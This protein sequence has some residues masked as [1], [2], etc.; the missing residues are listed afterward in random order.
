[1]AT[2]DAL[3][4]IQN[5]GRAR[6][7]GFHGEGRRRTGAFCRQSSG[8]FGPVLG[9][10]YSASILLVQRLMDGA[11]P[12]CPQLYFGVV[13]VRD[14]ADL[15]IR[16]MTQPAAKG[17]R[18]LAVAGDFMTMLDIAKA[19]KNRMGSA[20]Q[21]VPTR[22]LPNWLVRLASM[23]DPAVK[24]I[25][26]ELGKVKNAPTRRRSACLAGPRVRTRTPSSPPPKA[27]SGS[28]F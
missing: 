5:S 27:F 19:L 21:K 9:P 4:K 2:T 8:V 17:E 1:M 7:L 23:R 12:G 15:H 18:F 16:A 24:L 25:L 20:A 13:D 11:L 26:P 3:R 22:Q 14:V 10:D 6:G 28:T